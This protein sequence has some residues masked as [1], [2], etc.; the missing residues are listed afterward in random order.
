MYTDIDYK[1]DPIDKTEPGEKLSWDVVKDNIDVAF[2]DFDE[3][4][5]GQYG[6]DNTPNAS[7][8]WL[9]S[10]IL[11][12]AQYD[13]TDKVTFGFL[14]NSAFAFGS[15]YQTYTLSA[16]YMPNR[17]VDLALTF[18]NNQHRFNNIGAAFNFN[19]FP[20]NIYLAVD[21]IPITFSRSNER[22][23]KLP[24]QIG[25]INYSVGVNWIFGFNKRRWDDDKDGVMNKR[26][27]CPNTMPEEFEYVDKSGCVP[28]TDGDGV[29]DYKD[30]CPD[31]PS[32][33][34]GFIS[35]KGCPLDSDGDGVFDYLDKCPDTPKEA[36][37][38]VD[39][40]GCPK[41]SD[42]DG[43]PDYL[44]KCP[45][46]DL[47]LVG[48]IGEDG[49]ALDSDGDGIP[50]YLDACPEIAGV[51]SNNGCPEQKVKVEDDLELKADVLEEEKKKVE[52]LFQKALNGI[53]FETG[54]SII[55]AKS[56]GIL[57]EVVKVMKENPTYKLTING[58][59]D[60]TGSY[61]KNVQLSKDRAKSVKDYLVKKG[62]EDKRLESFGFG[63][64]KPIADNKTPQGRAK[65]RRVE[66]VLSFI[67]TVEE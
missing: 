5:K 1:F 11:L 30:E 59:I 63:P 39:S 27:K 32:E 36:Y 47:N 20:L 50:D 25:S 28:D 56:F 4:I 53:E 38:M 24:N 29:P 57:D 54:K 14:S 45:D 7:S 61:D 62:V 43:V 13:L 2:E 26:D 9:N 40:K 8:T 22:N 52:K 66:F 16:N 41:D 6:I 17:M 23:P 10:K 34:I 51:A 21:Q 35:E 46:T 37:G 44:D 42:F 15:M 19:L 12:A 60:N 58:H 49:C 65:N 3:K 18:T 48:K 31:T 64:D 55:K 33:A 67:Q